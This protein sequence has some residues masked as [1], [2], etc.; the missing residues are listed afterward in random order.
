MNSYDKNTAEGGMIAAVCAA[1]ESAVL[2]KCIDGKDIEVYRQYDLSHLKPEEVFDEIL[3]ALMLSDKPSVFFE[4]LKNMGQLD[5]WFPEVAALDGIRQNEKYHRE[6]DAWVH[7][8]LV[9]DRAACERINTVHPLGFMIAAL[10]HDFGKAVTFSVDGNGEVHSYRH[11]TEGLPLVRN[12]LERLECDEELIDYVLNMTELHM[13]PNIKAAAGS[14]IKS[15]NKMFDLSVEPHDL[16]LLADCDNLGRLP[17]CESSRDFLMSRLD[18]FNKVMSRPFVTENDL[19]EAG[20]R[21]CDELSDVLE[22]AHKL[23]LACV[24]KSNALRQTLAYAKMKGLK[25]HDGK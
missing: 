5:I 4:E 7:T 20:L 18:I 23:R 16:I 12:F 6:G 24:E 9:L 17:V 1:K 3:E 10:C 14:R 8:M 11:E 15:T 19:F 22:Y 21:P 13:Q 25:C 2:G